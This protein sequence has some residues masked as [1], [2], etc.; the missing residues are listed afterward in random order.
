MKDEIVRCKHCNEI[1]IACSWEEFTEYRN[2]KEA[3]IEEHESNCV[4]NPKNDYDSYIAE[5]EEK[6]DEMH[7]ATE[8]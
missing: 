2:S 5:Q 3:A 8:Q 4:E 1:I 7:E 6:S